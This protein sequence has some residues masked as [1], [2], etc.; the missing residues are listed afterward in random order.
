MAGAL[1]SFR[2]RYPPKDE[3]PEKVAVRHGEGPDSWF[4]YIVSFFRPSSWGNHGATAL[5]KQ[6]P[7]NHFL[8]LL[9]FF[10]LEVLYGV[11]FVFLGGLCL[12][13]PAFLRLRFWC[14]QW[15]L[16]WLNFFVWLEGQPG[17][18]YVR[19]WGRQV[20]AIGYSQVPREAREALSSYSTRVLWPCYEGA[21]LGFLVVTFVV[22]LLWVLFKVVLGLCFRGR[23]W[24]LGLGLF[25]FLGTSAVVQ[26]DYL[27]AHTLEALDAATG[28]I[29]WAYVDAL[30]C[31]RKVRGALEAKAFH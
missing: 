12:A 2:V 20:V 31:P 26:G 25:F 7:K 29:A 21:L 27:V 13:I 11:A 16:R 3:V 17:I 5:E 10:V 15:R 30:T 14:C 18:A 28:D 9:W 6:W 19:S 22:R 1:G 23:W 4:S 8:N 24:F